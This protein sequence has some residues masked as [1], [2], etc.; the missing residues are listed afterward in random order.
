MEEIKANPAAEEISVATDENLT[1]E[2]NEV[3]ENQEEAHLIEE[4]N[5]DAAQQIARQLRA[6]RMQY[7][8]R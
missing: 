4:M 1:Q 2:V 8:S 6:G 5:L 3:T 7:A